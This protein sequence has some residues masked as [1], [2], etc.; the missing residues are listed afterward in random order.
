MRHETS[1]VFHR[2]HRA[3]RLF[4]AHIELT[5]RCNLRCIHCLCP[6]RDKGRKELSTRGLKR[7]LDRL[8][9]AGFLTVNLSGGEP[10]LRE[11]FLELYAHARAKGLIVTILTNGTL[12][13]PPLIAYLSRHKPYAVELTLNGI[14]PRTYSAVT[15]V[16]GNLGQ[17]MRNIRLLRT[18]GVPVVVK[19]NLLRANQHEIGSIKRWVDKVLGK[20]LFRYDAAVQPRLDS[21]KAPLSQRLSYP[22][23]LRSVA[24]EPEMLRKFQEELRRDPPRRLRRGQC[25]YHCSSWETQIFVNPAGGARFCM[26]SNEFGFDLLATPPAEGMAGMRAAI[27]AKTF[28]GSSG[29]A[30]CRLRALCAWCPAKAALEMGAAES[31]IPFHCAFTKALARARSEARHEK[32][33]LR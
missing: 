21:S 31:P 10:L 11:D 12:L 6:S 19:A 22:E 9:G 4:A 3:A 14:T 2:R 24:R 15:G 28:S 1:D 5:Y 13:T 17:V 16:P 20:R 18:Q 32:I 26:F 7:V 29:C 23:I 33:V 30:S 25:L 27:A 8:A